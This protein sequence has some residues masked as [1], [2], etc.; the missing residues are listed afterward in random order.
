ML[1]SDV[2]DE[3]KGTRESEIPL[4]VPGRRFDRSHGHEREIRI[5]RVCLARLYCGVFRLK[6]FE[7]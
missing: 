1:A 4:T 6:C 2:C 7:R 5:P 3:A